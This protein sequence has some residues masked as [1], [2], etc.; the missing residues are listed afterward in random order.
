MKRH[1]LVV[2][3]WCDEVAREIAVSFPYSTADLVDLASHF[4]CMPRREAMVMCTSIAA[5]AS[6]NGYTE[7]RA[8]E[9]MKD[10]EDMLGAVIWMLR[11]DARATYG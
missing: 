1:A 8:T 9:R 11:R 10:P 2:E 5:V 3:P 4:V 6:A 7:L